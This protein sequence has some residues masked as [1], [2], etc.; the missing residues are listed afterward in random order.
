MSELLC[1]R[2]GGLLHEAE[3]LA[4]IGAFNLADNDIQVAFP[5][6]RPTSY[7]R[8]IQK[9]GS[10]K[11]GAIVSA[12]PWLASSWPNTTVAHLSFF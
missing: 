8:T 1:R 4:H 6:F 9:Y 11:R 7:L 2:T 3:P 12:S 10:G 5:V